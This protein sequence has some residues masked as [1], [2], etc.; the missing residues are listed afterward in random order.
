MRK[1]DGSPLPLLDRA[2]EFRRVES[3]FA[4]PRAIQLDA[5]GLSVIVGNAFHKGHSLAHQR[6]TQDD[7]RVLIGNSLPQR[8]IDRFGGMAVAFEDGPAVRFPEAADI[9]RHD[10]LRPSGDLDVIQIDQRG[11]SGKVETLRQPSRL[12]DLS[13]RLLPVAHENIDAPRR[14]ASALRQRVADASG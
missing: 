5:C 6:M 10:V 7:R 12:G 3:E 14:T 2:V 11:Q 8:Q 1:V 9:G 13:L 4:H